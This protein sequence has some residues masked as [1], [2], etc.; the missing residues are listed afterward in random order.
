MTLE[1]VKLQVEFILLK[2]IRISFL[3]KKKKNNQ[4]GKNSFHE[5]HEALGM[6]PEEGH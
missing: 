3:T 1:V 2:V 6:G 4:K 5:K